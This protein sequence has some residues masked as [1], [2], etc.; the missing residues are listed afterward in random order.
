MEMEA[1]LGFV[2]EQGAAFG[3]NLVAALAIFVIGRWV[4]KL[5][6]R[7]LV[8][9]L[10]RAEVEP[11]LVRFVG[12]IVNVV[13]TIFVVL[14]AISQ[15][16]VQTTSLI[17]VLGAAGLAV[18]LALQGSLAN[19]A[20]GV[21]II[22]F[23]PYKSGDYIEAGGVAGTVDEVQIF[24]TVLNTPD[25][26][27]VI[28]PNGQIMSGVIT[29]YSSHPIRRLDLTASVSYDADT[30]HVRRVLTG[31]LDADERVLSEPAYNVRMMT[32]GESSIDW[33]V[34]PWVNTADYWETCWD[35][36]ERIKRRFDEEGIAIPFPQRD[37]HVYSHAG[38]G[39]RA[40]EALIAPGAPAREG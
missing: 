16:G 38:G 17:A 2:Q 20:A 12:N 14:A 40:E 21:L 23:R 26:R 4:A 22:V 18:G 31:I 35:L 1:I 6:N 33:I 25:N 5:V 28:V 34:R 11:I 24:T 30:D 8:K 37:V 15:L 13:L 27:R 3:I 39:D 19:F 32:H 9:G 7:V 10:N 36:T 29:N